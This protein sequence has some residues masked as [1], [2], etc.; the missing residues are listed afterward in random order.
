[1]D[2]FRKQFAAN[3]NAICD[4]MS[5][6]K[7]GSG[8]ATG[9][10]KLFNMSVPAAHKWLTGG[11]LPELDKLP[12]ICSILQCTADELIFG[13]IKPGEQPEHIPPDLSL[14]P[15]AS[16]AGLNVEISS[17]QVE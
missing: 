9:L 13:C 6:P 2:T 3:L 14:E 4:R 5:I 12:R 10:A 15:P 17:C 16:G 8:R 7:S 1:M 11:S